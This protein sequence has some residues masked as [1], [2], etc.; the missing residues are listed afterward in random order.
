MK[1]LHHV[2]LLVAVALSLNL[3][4]LHVAAQSDFLT[5]YLNQPNPD[6]I[7]MMR[8]PPTHLQQDPL[9][10]LSNHT[11]IANFDANTII[12]AP[13]VDEPY[14][15]HIQNT[16]HLQVR[17]HLASLTHDPRVISVE[18]DVLREPLVSYNDPQRGNQWYL[19]HLAL[20]E[21]HANMQLFQK[22]YGGLRDIIVAVIDTGLNYAHPEFNARLWTNQG[23]IAGNGIDDDNNGIIDDIHGINSDLL[24]NE[25]NDPDGHGT[26]VA[27]IIGAATN[28]AFGIVGIAPNISIMPIR[29]SRFFS[30][31][32]REMLPASA[33][34]NGLMYA[35]H[36]GAHIVNMSFGSTQY[37]ASEESLM[38]SLS[39]HM[40][41]VAAAGNSGRAI[42]SQPIF[43]AAY[44][45]VIGVMAHRSVPRNDRS[46]LSNFSNFDDNTVPHL[47]YDI[48]APGEG[49]FSTH[50]NNTFMNR[51]GT[52]MAAAMVSGVA[53]LLV[54]KLGGFEDVDAPTIA[55]MIITQSKAEIGRIVNNTPLMYPKLNALS[56]LLIDPIIND[57]RINDV[58]NAFTLTV[59][60]N[61]LLE[62]IEV[63]VN[64]VKI[65][66]IQ[67]LSMTKLIITL[68]K[69]QSS[70]VV[71]TLRHPDQTQTSRQLVVVPDVLVDSIIVNPS[72]LH[73]TT[74]QPQTLQT[75][76][77]PTN[78]THRGV[79]FSSLHPHI[80]SVSAQGVVTP[81]SNGVTAIEVTSHDLAFT[82]SIPVHVDALASTLTFNVNDA[83]FPHRSQIR[84]NGGD[85]V[86][87]T[88]GIN[89]INGAMVDF[90]ATLPS[91]YVVL[92]WVVNGQ[93]IETRSLT[94]QITLQQPQ[95]H[96]VLEIVRRGD[97][98]NDGVLTTTDL[99]Q[100]QRFLAGILP[101][102]LER[103]L[104]SDVNES[105]TVTSTDLVQLMRLLAGI[106]LDAKDD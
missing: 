49:I 23:E 20:S 42:S 85:G 13:F 3:G 45:G 57:I 104:A 48:M 18:M 90:E 24:T 5:S 69:P 99:I 97:L 63:F 83:R 17:R 7:I 36:H 93:R 87:F 35:Y 56:T 88:S 89:L 16:S 96:V 65:S 1:T 27:G 30:E 86:I 19:S 6:L 8:R 52:S 34:L 43:P 79:T 81:L 84:V 21:A 26:H 75:L 55:R 100:L 10:R 72:S 2:V 78:A 91:R 103:S 76:V 9:F 67:H 12:N 50:L 44:D 98:N 38:R 15:I 59:N 25:F 14:I 73:F 92:A 95:T 61:F 71:L 46:W 66:N 105:Q 41:L 47:S 28:N 60:G 33:I 80:A 37:L 29:A 40:I 62:G 31:H 11:Q 70:E 94:Q 68:P 54:S 32:N 22:S 39:Q 64:D 102:T 4:R 77:L 51:N 74:S 53:A 58:G 106:P 82:T 101:F